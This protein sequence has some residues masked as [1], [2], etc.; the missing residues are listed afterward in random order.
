MRL[1]KG[2]AGLVAAAVIGPAAFVHFAP[3]TATR[4]ALEGERQCSGLVRKEIDLPGG[5]HYVYLEG[6][7][8]EALMLFHGFGADKDNFTRIARHLVPHYRVVIPDHIGFGESSHPADADYS[9]AAQAGRLHELAATLRLGRVHLGGSSM[10]GHIA[11]SYALAHKDDVASLWL[12]DPGG[13]RSGP[14]SELVKAIQQTGKNPLMARTTDDF[15][16]VYEFVMSDPPWI[17]H[18][19]LGVMARE[20]IANFDLEQRIFAQL[21]SDHLEERV[22]GLT[23]PTLIVWGREDRA[24]DVGTADVL[25]GL[26]P[27]SQ[28][29]IMEHIG[30]LPHLED[31]RRSA[32]DY[33]RFRAGLH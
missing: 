30:H 32:D 29:I 18:A 13:I 15:E 3:E 2:L 19:M 21:Q 17:P 22:R 6:G 27:N 8:G 4:L 24:I 28:V 1:L 12:L 25:H 10:G 7:S 9:P 23:T 11:M 20:R 26:L 16:K 31:P 33:L 5:L 14:P